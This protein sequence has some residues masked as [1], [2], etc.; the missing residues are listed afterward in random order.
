MSQAL[1]SFNTKKPQQGFTLVELMVGM[2]LALMTTVIIAEVMLNS[3]GQRRTTTSGSDAQVNGALGLFSVTRDLQMAGYGLSSNRTALGCTIKGKYGSTSAITPLKLAPVEIV[4]ATSSAPLEIRVLRSGRTSF[5]VPTALASDYLSTATSLAV[6]SSTGT[7]LG[8][9]LMLIPASWDSTKWCTI[10]QANAS[11]SNTLTNTVIPIAT[12]TSGNWNQ[13]GA[14]S[15]APN[16]GTAVASYKTNDSLV[17]MGSINYKVYKLNAGGDSLTLSSM[18]SSGTMGSA[19][20]VAPQIVAMQAYYGRDT[21]SPAD[22]VIDVYDQTTPTTTDGWSRVLAIRIAL[23]ARGAQYEKTEVTGA[24]IEWKVGDDASVTGSADCSS[25]SGK[26][27]TL[28]S[29]PT[30]GDWGHYRYKV[31]DTVVP[32]RNILWSSS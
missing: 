30:S 11:G 14:N 32:L 15:V 29:K 21:S 6:K 10:V 5:A 7:A 4:A 3:E 25:G 28:V 9:V 27:V 24:S 20:V 18:D 13:T 16:A 8:D 2:T 12:S 26:C 19:D 17:N 31:Y 1:S 23:V 22:G